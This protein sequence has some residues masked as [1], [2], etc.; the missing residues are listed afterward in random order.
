MRTAPHAGT[1]ERLKGIFP[2]GSQLRSEPPAPTPVWRGERFSPQTL[3]KG[4]LQVG[5]NAGA[6]II[7]GICLRVFSHHNA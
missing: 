7:K 1:L 2:V 4:H 5:T 6:F 3:G